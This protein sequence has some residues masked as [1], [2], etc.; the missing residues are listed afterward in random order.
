MWVYTSNNLDIWPVPNGMNGLV[1]RLSSISDFFTETN[2]YL[3]RA[4]E[5]SSDLGTALLEYARETKFKSAGEDLVL[6]MH[7]TR[8]LELGRPK[9]DNEFKLIREKANAAQIRHIR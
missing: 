1:D 7:S 4:N 8:M 2:T 3:A 6:G 5:D 9:W